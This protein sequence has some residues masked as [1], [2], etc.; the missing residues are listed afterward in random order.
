MLQAARMVCAKVPGYRATFLD[1]KRSSSHLSEG[2]A[3]RYG[4]ME[5]EYGNRGGTLWAEAEACLTPMFGS[6]Q[7]GHMEKTQGQASQRVEKHCGH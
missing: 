7:G 1:L 6:L 3:K 2:G 5:S 4:G